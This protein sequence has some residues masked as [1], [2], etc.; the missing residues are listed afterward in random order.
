[1]GL[2]GKEKKL[3]IPAAMLSA[4]GIAGTVLW[5]KKDWVKCIA[6]LHKN[7]AG[8]VRLQEEPEVYITKATEEGKDALFAYLSTSQWHLADHIADG[9]FWINKKEEILLLSQKTVMKEYWQ[10]SASRPFFAE[11][12]ECAETAIDEIEK[13]VQMEMPIE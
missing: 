10:W 13:I 9:F 2:F 7:P 5:Q 3:S 11:E 6:A 8:W 4:A 1:M 12:T